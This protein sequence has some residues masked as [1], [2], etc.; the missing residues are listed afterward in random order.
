MIPHSYI[1]SHT[2][3]QTY[4]S[5]QSKLDCIVTPSESSST[6]SLTV[7]RVSPPSVFRRQTDSSWTAASRRLQTTIPH[8]STQ[9]YKFG[10]FP[11]RGTIALW[12]GDS[13]FRIFFSV[14]ASLFLSVAVF[15][16]CLIFLVQGKTCW[17]FVISSCI[18][19]FFFL[20]SFLSFFSSFMEVLLCFWFGCTAMENDVIR[21]QDADEGKTFWSAH[22]FAYIWRHLS[23]FIHNGNRGERIRAKV[24]LMENAFY[25]LFFMVFIFFFFQNYFLIIFALK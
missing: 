19:S 20:P 11:S 22:F 1:D 18:S 4:V 25:K 21:L 2:V 3:V 8:F 15:F 17:T 12:F 5:D 16:F 13:T 7:V 24:V 23:G 9:V 10:S 14:L 6:S